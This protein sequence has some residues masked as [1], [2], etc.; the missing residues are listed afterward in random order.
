MSTYLP[1]KTAHKSED[2][3]V[4]LGKK[5]KVSVRLSQ[6]QQTLWPR[7]FGPGLLQFYYLGS[8]VMIS[9]NESHESL[10]NP[11]IHQVGGKL[12]FLGVLS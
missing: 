1:E 5:N 6:N 11:P 9:M 12:Y 10:T 3:F 4:F 8:E 2:L 7:Y